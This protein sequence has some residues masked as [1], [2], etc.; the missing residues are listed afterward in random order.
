MADIVS[1]NNELLLSDIYLENVSTEYH[2]QSANIIF[3]SLF[4]PSQDI[5]PYSIIA[6][7]K[8]YQIEDVEIDLANYLDYISFKVYKDYNYTPWLIY[9]NEIPDPV[10][11]KSYKQ[12]A[13]IDKTLLTNFVATS[14]RIIPERHLEILQEFNPEE[15]DLQYINP[16]VMLDYGRLEYLFEDYTRPDGVTDSDVFDFVRQLY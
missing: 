11:T 14:S 10:D 2:D 3:Y 4:E 6:R 9:L 16:T 5:L 12:F 7:N 13:L 8:F 15:L 1:K